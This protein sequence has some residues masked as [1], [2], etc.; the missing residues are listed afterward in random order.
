MWNTSITIGSKGYNGNDIYDAS[1]DQWLTD[2]LNTSWLFSIN[3]LGYGIRNSLF[4]S[5]D[6]LTNL[7]SIKVPLG[8]A[9]AN[10]LFSIETRDIKLY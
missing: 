7:F 5:Y 8:F 10:Q 9:S 4:Q 1:T 6:P 3:G 2:T